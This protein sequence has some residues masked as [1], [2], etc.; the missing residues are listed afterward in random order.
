MPYTTSSREMMVAA[1]QGVRADDEATRSQTH[2]DAKDHLGT[3]TH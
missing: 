2:T 3:A 1:E